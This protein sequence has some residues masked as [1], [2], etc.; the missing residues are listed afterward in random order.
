[1][2]YILGIVD[3]TGVISD[4]QYA[5]DMANSFCK[6]TDRQCGMNSLYWRGPTGEGG[7]VLSRARAVRDWIVEKRGRTPGADVML[8]GYSRGA[9]IVIMTA[10]YLDGLGIPVHSLWLFDAVARHVYSGGEVIPA[11]VAYSRHAVRTD[12]AEMIR[13]Y[14]GSI[15]V[16]QNP[17]RP[18]FGH[19]GM[20][21]V[22]TPN[23]DHQH[24]VFRGSHGALGGVGWGNVEEDPACQREIATWMNGCFRARGLPVT[25]TAVDPPPAPITPRP[26]PVR[27]ATPRDGLYP[28]GVRRPLY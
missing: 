8:M 12:D 5:I 22:R 21:A 2:A 14:E 20:T 1:M 13:R 7:S 27:P 18:S 9:S 15:G 16:G 26:P 17:M 4:A 3:G 25:L 6:Q 23:G 19:T 10:E 24:R 28:G 11:N